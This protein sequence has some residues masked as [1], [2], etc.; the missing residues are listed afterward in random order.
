MRAFWSNFENVSFDA[1]GMT[2]CSNDACNSSGTEPAWATIDSSTDPGGRS[3]ME[4]TVLCN[5]EA[6]MTASSTEG[7]L[8]VLSAGRHR[9]ARRGA[10]F[11]EYASYLAGERWSDRPACTHPALASLARLVNDLTSDGERGHLATLIPSV[12]GL[13]GDD[14]RVPILLSVLAASSALPI[15]ASM[16][17]GALATG[18]VRCEQLLE[19]WDGPEV[20]RAR[21]R[22]RAAF[23]LTPGAENWARDFIDQVA[24]RGARLFAVNDEALLRTA[25]IGIADACV[26]DA[27]SRLAGMLEQ[28]IEEC[29]AILEPVVVEE[30][31]V[32]LV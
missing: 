6:H 1:D 20:E 32:A 12:V 27:D 14:P 24:P 25:A 11:M 22:I 2:A 21:T 8:P 5:E 3:K 16:R 31:A 15:A 30:R 10:C 26:P 28:A 17:Q 19:D 18:L 29:T 23:L 9:N 7:F 4:T 13:N